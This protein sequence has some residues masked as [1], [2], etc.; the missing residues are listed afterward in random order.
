MSTE[1]VEFLQSMIFEEDRRKRRSSAKI[2]VD[3]RDFPEPPLLEEELPPQTTDVQVI[4]AS[5]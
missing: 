2:I 3:P 5:P 1:E 4:D